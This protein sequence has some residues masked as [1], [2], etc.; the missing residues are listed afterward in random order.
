VHPAASLGLVTHR[1][2]GRGRRT[3]EHETRGLD[4]LSEFGALGQ[5]AVPRMDGV[6]P[7]TPGSGH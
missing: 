5:E 1:P 3:D 2:H 6:G 4:S 7:G